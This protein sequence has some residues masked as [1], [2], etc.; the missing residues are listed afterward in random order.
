MGDW[1]AVLWVG[2]FTFTAQQIPSSSLSVFDFDVIPPAYWHR[3]KP[4]PSPTTPPC[5]IFLHLNKVFSLHAIKAYIGNRGIALLI[6]GF[7]TEWRRVP[8]F[9]RSGLL[10]IQGATT[11][12]IEKEVG[13]APN[14][15]WTLWRREKSRLGF[16]PINLSAGNLVTVLNMVSR[17]RSF[18]RFN[19]NLWLV[20][21]CWHVT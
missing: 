2:Y 6:L 16:E 7:C 1:F 3:H 18:R 19:A 20:A 4:S 21:E 8:N 15:V 9:T 13:W 17:L 10:Y 5:D 12:S 14:S 11:V